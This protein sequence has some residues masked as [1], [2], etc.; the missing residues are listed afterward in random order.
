MRWV[1][2]FGYGLKQHL[3]GEDIDPEMKRLVSSQ[4]LVR[5]QGAQSVPLELLLELGGYLQ[6]CYGR[7]Q[8]TLYQLSDLHR[9]VDS[10]S[11]VVGSCERILTTPVP[12]AYSIHLRQLLYVYCLTIPFV[13]VDEFGLWTA[14]VVGLVAFTV[15]GIEEIGLE[16]EN[17]FGRDPN[18]LPL[19]GICGGVREYVELVVRRCGV[20]QEKRLGL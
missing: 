10:L 7:R 15:F 3:R 13:F 8:V 11:E 14:V 16:I 12:L 18:D 4:L 6:G 20:G 5:L 9:L 1:A 17:P 19:D 2:A